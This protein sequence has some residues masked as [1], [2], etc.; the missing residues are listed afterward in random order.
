MTM[1]RRWITFALGLLVGVGV[2]LVA[3]RLGRRAPSPPAAE[4]HA[5]KDLYQCAMH[6]SVVS[7]KPGICPICGMKLQKADAAGGA[8]DSGGKG[9]IL[10]YRNP[11]NPDV[12][13]PTPAKDSM[14]MDYVPVYEGEE[15]AQ[16]SIAGHAVVKLPQWR[17]QLIGVATTQARYRTL[18]ASIRTVGK[19]AYDP[20]LYTAITEYREA[21]ISREKVKESPWPDVHE[22]ADALVRASRTKLKLM[23]LGDDQ[24]DKLAAEGSPTN[25]LYGQPGGSLW[26]YAEVY[27]ND[28]A[29]ISPG[30]DV[31]VTLPALPGRLIRGTIKAIDPVLNPNTRTVRVRAEIPNERGILKP[32]MFVNVTIKAPLGEAL[33]V[34]SDAILDTGTRQLAFV[35]IGD[36]TFDPREVKI[37]HLAEGYYEVLSGIKTGEQV[38]TQANF[39]LDSE[40]KLRATGQ[41]ASQDS[42]PRMPGMKGGEKK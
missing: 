10:Y 13:S 5:H 15:G 35:E 42:M 17:Q 34:P 2:A 7:D 27:E 22:Q 32:E 40:S 41:K 1:N 12:T 31:E 36:G 20:D 3:P 14:G 37:G 11:M 39:L 16:T 33:T 38:V 9:R 23:G 24:I 25:L 4:T 18:R 28:I 19:I 30:Q 6:P 29:L 21:L 26:V 8:A